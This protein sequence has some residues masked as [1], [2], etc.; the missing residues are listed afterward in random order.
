MENSFNIILKR[1]SIRKYEVKEVPME[2]INKLLQA[3]MNA[4]SASNQQP[5]HFVV[6]R[7]KALLLEL[8][9]IHSGLSNLKES[10]LAILVCGEPDA[11]T[12]KYYWEQDCSA[13]TEN[14]LIAATALGLGAVWHGIKPEESRDSEIFRKT[15]NIPRHIKPFSVITVGYP[16]ENIESSDR[17][18]EKRVHYANY[19]QA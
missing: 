5:W 16:A 3:A 18:N 6:I 9:Q 11:T 19:W 4:P 2:S 12:L 17:F 13:A 14:M 8:S 7:D 1:R 15:L 10:P